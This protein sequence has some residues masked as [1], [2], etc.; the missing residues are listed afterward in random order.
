MARFGYDK[1]SDDERAAVDLCR[2]IL[3]P[4][5]METMQAMRAKHPDLTL[6]QA[7]LL[8]VETRPW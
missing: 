1:C 4:A 7:C 6:P 2:E 5:F 3:G 8:Y